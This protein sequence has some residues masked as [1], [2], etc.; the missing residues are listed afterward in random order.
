M[1]LQCV[2]RTEKVIKRINISCQDTIC[3]LISLAQTGSWPMPCPLLPYRVLGNQDACFKSESGSC[4]VFQSQGAFRW[5]RHPL[6]ASRGQSLAMEPWWV[7][8]AAVTYAESAWFKVPPALAI[9]M[10][11]VLGHC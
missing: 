6:K 8:V 7:V 2:H 4:T 10:G 1:L 11:G 9:V 5:A 3:L